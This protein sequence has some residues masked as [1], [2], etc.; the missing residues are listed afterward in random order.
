[1]QDFTFDEEQTLSF[2]TIRAMVNVLNSELLKNPSLANDLLLFLN[3]RDIEIPVLSVDKSNK[4]ISAQYKTK[5]S[6]QKI[7]KLKRAFEGAT[8][9]ENIL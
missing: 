6:S 3:E 7:H 8:S 4:N 1:M 2:T 5:R 9:V